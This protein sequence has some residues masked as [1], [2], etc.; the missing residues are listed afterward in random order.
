MGS[1]HCPGQVSYRSI[2][3]SLNRP[4]TLQGICIQCSQFPVPSLGPHRP[5]FICFFSMYGCGGPKVDSDH[6][7]RTIWTQ[8]DFLW[9]RRISPLIEGTCR[10]CCINLCRRF[11]SNRTSIFVLPL[12]CRSVVLQ[13]KCPLRTMRRIL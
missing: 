13:S 11:T 4:L 3:A 10:V 5:I 2:R 8:C 12:F 9:R 1:I 7:S 6:Y